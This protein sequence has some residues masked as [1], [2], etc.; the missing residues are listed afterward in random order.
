MKDFLHTHQGRV[1][2]LFVLVLTIFIFFNL[3]ITRP[4]W[5]DS[6]GV[7]LAPIRVIFEGRTRST[8]VN[9]LNPND[10][11]C[12]YK[13]SIVNLRMDEF[14]IRKEV[15]HP[16][17]RELLSRDLIRFSPRRATVEAKGWQTIRLM[18][19]KPKD[20]PEGEYRV[21]LKAAPIPDTDIEKDIENKKEQGLSIKI[22][23]VMNVTIPIIIRHGQGKAGV[24]ISYKPVFKKI[25]KKEGYF[26]I[27]DVER[28]GNHSVFA[29]IFAHHTPL[30]KEKYQI[31]QLKGFSI[32]TPNRNHTLRIP[33]SEEDYK[34]ISP[35]TLSFEILNRDKGQEPVLGTASFK[36]K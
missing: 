36:L 19:R 2:P 9:L 15:A 7:M 33:V 20:L 8:T 30:N 18:V 23:Y 29:D 21:H 26:L 27:T 4:V 1:L 35:G 28:M 3:L 14:G 5:S 12:T 13:I 25:E 31:G 10:K 6:T 17:S 22:N 24:E 34:H 16:D 32:Y 11:A